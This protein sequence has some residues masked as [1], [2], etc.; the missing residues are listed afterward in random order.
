M[1]KQ[2][3]ESPNA[4]RGRVALLV[5]LLLAVA[6]VLAY[7]FTREDPSRIQP[8]T[9]SVSDF[10][11]DWRCLECGHKMTDRAG[12]GPHVCPQ[13]GRDAMYASIRWGCP[14]HGAVPV[15]FQYDARGQPTQVRVGAG[16]WA[17][18]IDED[19]AWNIHCPRCGVVMA[20]AETP[21][22]A[23]VDDD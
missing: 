1:L 20:P 15:A 7:Q 11:V 14:Q 10:L 12:G 18:H 8:L 16:D 3:T 4:S 6:G 13:C 23:R 5:I 22:S 21:R 17:P 2:E 19:G 9:R